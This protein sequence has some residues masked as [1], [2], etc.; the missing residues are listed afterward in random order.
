MT[1]RIDDLEV[2]PGDPFQ[3]DSL[4]R[5]PLVELIERLGGSFVLSI[6]KKAD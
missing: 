1:Y 4:E 5:K 6:D 3:H 2:P